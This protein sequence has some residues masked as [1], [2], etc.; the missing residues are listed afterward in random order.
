MWGGIS[1]CL[2]SELLCEEI[3][4][5]CS[6]KS[7]TDGKGGGGGAVLAVRFVENVSQVMG[8]RFFANL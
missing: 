5:A 3:P 8:N 1:G 4:I 7:V 6:G 2:W